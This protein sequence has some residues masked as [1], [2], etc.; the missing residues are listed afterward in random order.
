MPNIFNT[1]SRHSKCR[2]FL[3]VPPPSIGCGFP[4]PASTLSLNSADGLRGWALC[5][6][7]PVLNPGKETEG[8]SGFFD[9]EHVGLGDVLGPS[10]GDRVAGGGGYV[11]YTYGGGS[12]AVTLGS[13]DAATVLRGVRM[14]IGA[15]AS[16]DGARW[17]RVLGPGADGSLLAP[18]E[19]A[20]FDG[21]MVGWPCV[22]RDGAGYRMYYS[23]FA[24]ADGRFVV[25]LATG[26][27]GARW[28]K[29]GPVFRG[30][31]AGA[32]DAK[33]AGRRSICRDP[34]PPGRYR[35][36]YEAHG[37]DGAHSIGLATSGDGEAWERA[38]DEPVLRR[39]DDPDAWDSGGVGS[40]HVVWLPERRRWR[41]YYAGSR[42]GSSRL[43]VG[44]AESTDEEGRCFERV[45]L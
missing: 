15:Y 5:E 23:T 30:G 8:E 2:T 39:S 37:P 6:G 26:P 40:P 12:E 17:A 28:A 1:K 22:L 10:D 29:A 11:M 35:M 44:V 19:P 38:G 43:S 13:G 14:A 16:P 9:S 21:R 25:A 34:R 27:D 45:Q 33:G 18:G 3:I 4:P 32:F 42:R 36:W 24:A 20:E 41:M 31:A 7:N